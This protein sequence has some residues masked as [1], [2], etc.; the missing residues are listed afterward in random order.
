M[1]D[2]LFARLKANEPTLADP[3]KL[4]EN[5]MSRLK[6]RRRVRRWVL[7]LRVASLAASLLL[8][9]GLALSFG[10]EQA[11]KQDPALTAYQQGMLSQQKDVNRYFSKTIY[12]QIKDYSNE[13]AQ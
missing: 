3:D 10:S 11:T 5:I 9:F 13:N 6:P 8:L 2:E 1:E 7:P 4:T 12:D